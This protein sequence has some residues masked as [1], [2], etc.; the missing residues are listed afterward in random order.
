M[1]KYLLVTVVGLIAGFINVNAGGGSF[2]TIPT[3]I[4]VGLP[5]SVANG[6]NRIGILGMTLTSALTFRSKGVAHFKFA[7]FLAI[8]AIVGAYLGAKISIQLPPELFKQILSV[9]M[10]GMII[11]SLYRSKKQQVISEPIFSPLRNAVSFVSFFFVGLYGGFIQAG[12]GY[13]MILVLRLVHK[14]SLKDI[15]SIRVSVVFLFVILPVILFITNQKIEWVYA[16]ILALSVSLG[17]WVGVH[18]NVKSHDSEIKKVVAVSV[19]IMAAYMFF[20]G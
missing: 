6:T 8:P 14:M 11:F 7:G 2:L 10:V 15:A 20:K 4:L 1:M 13:L 18:W 16:I 3:L 5:P 19:V 17:G 12:V 9:L